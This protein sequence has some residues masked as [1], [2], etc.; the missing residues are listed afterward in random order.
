MTHPAFA[1]RALGALPLDGL[2]RGITRAWPVSELRQAAELLYDRIE[3][4]RPLRVKFGSDLDG[5]RRKLGALFVELFAGAPEWNGGH[6]VGPLGRPHAHIHITRHDAAAWLGHARAA[7]TAVGDER[8]ARE[9]VACLRPLAEAMVNEDA[10]SPRG[11]KREARYGPTRVAIAAATKGD[12]VALRD[13]LD[14]YPHVAAPLDPGSADVLHAAV[15]KGRDAVVGELV[16]RGIDV[17]KPAWVGA[18]M[19]TALCAARTR[20]KKGEATA[21]LLREAGAVGDVL[22]AAYLGELDLLERGLDGAPELVNE[23]DPASDL[24][25]STV[26]DH[27]VLG[28]SPRRT[29]EVLA[30][31]GARSP[32]H[33]YTLLRVAAD[34]GEPAVVARLLDIGADAHA[35]TAGWWV[36]DNECSR[37]LLAAGADVN[38]APS[39]WSSWIWLS[40]NGN[41]GKKDNPALVRALLAAGADVRSRA[42]GK[43]ALHFACKAGFVE[44][45]RLLLD[46]G[47]DP[48]A[49]DED[50]LTPLW[51]TMQSGPSVPREP[52][53]RLL[54]SG[55]ANPHTP[56]GKGLV[57]VEAV[58]ADPK[59][60]LVERRALL[61]LLA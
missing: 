52:V 13:V 35:V 23:P 20:G 37:L 50:G 54:L 19:M 10:P 46:A 26:V 14:A 40:C 5:E 24:Y 7:F 31:R 6:T 15:V 21:Q 11:A 49:I 3:R 27:A 36:L 25:R 29:V 38:H 57:L 12:V 8:A 22:T 59:R 30:S 55:G 34:R 42:F 18:V 41:N 61:A 47:A 56:N 17:N 43:T 39:R 1:H 60:P 53:V 51:S 45:V 16:D 33:G 4:D 28:R 32:A 44:T 9:V 48:N 2:D 58:A